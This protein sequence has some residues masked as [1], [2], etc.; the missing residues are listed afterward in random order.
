[1]H[2]QSMKGKWLSPLCVFRY[3][4]E[5]LELINHNFKTKET[6]LLYSLFDN[7]SK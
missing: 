4:E 7:S 5:V 3:S 2:K 1:M 6:S